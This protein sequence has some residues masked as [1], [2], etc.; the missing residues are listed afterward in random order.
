MHGLIS[1]S[2]SRW[3]SAAALGAA[4]LVPG[5]A[6][7][8]APAAKTPSVKSTDG[9]YVVTLRALPAEGLFAGEETDIEFLVG[10]AT[11]EDPIFGPA[12]V[13]RAEINGRFQMPAMPGMP[14]G[15]AKA[16]TEGQPGF[17]GVVTSFPHGG[18]YVMHL[19]IKPPAAEAFTVQFP[20]TVKDPQPNRPRPL[21]VKMDANPSTVRAGEPAELTLRIFSRQAPNTPVKQFER[22]H[23][24]LMHLVIVSRD[25]SSFNHLHPNFDP[26][27]GTF[28][29]RHTFPAGGEY[30]LFADVTPKDA[31]MQVLLSPLK[32][33]GAPATTAASTLQPSNPLQA[34]AG[35]VT[36]SIRPK[37]GPLKPRAD[38]TLTA[39]YTANGQPV[40]DFQPWLGALSHL[41]LIHEDAETFV[42]SHPQEEVPAAGQPRPSTL[43]FYARFPK[44]GLY[45]G[46]VQFQRAGK[47]ETA[48]FVV[49]VG[50]A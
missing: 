39:T 42:H 19:N 23:E 40:T 48:P 11:R 47:V 49:R 30:R 43:N 25:L 34:E 12:P 45:K 1:Q 3:L 18:K 17:Y 46:W 38:Q 15:V 32:V 50:E 37:E 35:G 8:Q 26:A 27:M 29:I 41:V 6:L 16:H 28:R 36:I 10:D 22:V 9:K 4:L 13:I 21:S 20:L 14:E 24:Q 44:P 31:G 5:S 33:E 7:A 2:F